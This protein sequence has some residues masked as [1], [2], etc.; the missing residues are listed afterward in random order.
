MATSLKAVL[1]Q[2]L[3]AAGKILAKNLTAKKIISHKG[4]E[5]INIVTQVDKAAEKAILALI[6]KHFPDHGILAEESGAQQGKQFKWIHVC[7]N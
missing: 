2:S 5:A 6:H 1:I 3:E 4:S 7:K